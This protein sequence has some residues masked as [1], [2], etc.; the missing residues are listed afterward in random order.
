MPAKTPSET[1]S[2]TTSTGSLSSSVSYDSKV[3]SFP[4]LTL[5]APKDRGYGYES[6]F[7]PLC[8][9]LVLCPDRAIRRDYFKL[10]KDKP[11]VHAHS[12]NEPRPDSRLF[13][14]DDT[15]C[16][17][18]SLLQTSNH[19]LL[20]MTPG[21]EEEMKPNKWMEGFASGDVY[22]LKVKDPH[23]ES[24]AYEDFGIPEKQ[25]AAEQKQFW[26]EIAAE[27]DIAMQA[28]FQAAIGLSTVII[29]LANL[30]PMKHD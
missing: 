30:V 3:L 21:E 5:N 23:E 25:P 19:H 20:Y 14:W 6:R 4:L 7:H 29:G 26:G 27:I 24:L 8:E 10:M 11:I 17:K 18:F 16:D 2:D 1:E 28:R 15:P 13:K 9:A 12:H 22:L